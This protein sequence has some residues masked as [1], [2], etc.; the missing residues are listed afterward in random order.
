VST[1]AVLDPLEGVAPDGSITT[2]VGREHVPAAFAPVVEAAIAAVRPDV[3]LYLYGSVATGRARPGGSDV[4]LIGV[5]LPA[6]EAKRISA[7]LSDRFTLV[8]RAVEIAAASP[9][10]LAG[11][12]DEAY[13]NRVFR[14]HYCV[15][16]SG[17]PRTDLDV[18][19]PADARAAR[20]FNGDIAAAARRW[21]RALDDGADPAAVARRM[22]RKSLVAAAGLV[23]VLDRTWT[24]DRG[25]AAHRWA[26]LE[27]RWAE[28][29]AA[30]LE[31]AER[32]PVVTRSRVDAVFDG[33]VSALVAAFAD[34]VG[35]WA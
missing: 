34:V 30:L 7:E 32:P 28:D 17:P 10:D 29:T 20:G 5:G 12:T 21:R 2:G 9:A 33:C 6:A 31:W 1:G 16:L 24:T 8:C 25:R 15:Q 23:S 14:R 11:D 22:A 35:L 19:F 4:D 27:P 26:E 3:A 18:V 13:G